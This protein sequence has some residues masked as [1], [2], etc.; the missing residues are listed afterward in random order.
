MSICRYPTAPSATA[1]NLDP[2]ESMHEMDHSP[3]PGHVATPVL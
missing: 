2:G 1:I 3:L